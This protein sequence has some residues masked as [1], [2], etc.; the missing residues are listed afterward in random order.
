MKSLQIRIVLLA[1][2][3]CF[4]HTALLSQQDGR[5][6]RIRALY[7]EA[8]S[9][10]NFGD[11][12]FRH[13]ITLNTNYPGIGLQTTAIRFIYFPRQVDPEN[14]PYLLTR[15][16]KKAVV[17]YNIAA[18]VHYTIEYLYDSSEQPVFYYW[19]EELSSATN[20]KRYYFHGGRL[21][22]IIADYSKDGTPVKYTRRKGFTREERE[23]AAE[24]MKKAAS[25]RSLFRQLV[26]IERL[27]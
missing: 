7:Q 18:S 20:Q 22:Q 24:V 12:F 11:A 17:T 13:E 4:A 23:S 8:Q 25:Y 27:K 6:G 3:L 26:A 9:L 19:S 2:V 21:I 10:E 14:N 15:T 1:G 5:I 16:L